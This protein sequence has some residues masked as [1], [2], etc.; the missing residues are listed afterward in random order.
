[1]P[2]KSKPLRKINAEGKNVFIE[3]HSVPSVPTL[4]PL[5]PNLVRLKDTLLK[6]AEG[7]FNKNQVKFLSG[8]GSLMESFYTLAGTEDDKEAQAKLEA[9]EMPAEFFLH[10]TP[11]MR[12]LA[13]VGLVKFLGEE[14]EE[15]FGYKS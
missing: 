15:L 2:R 1:M 9:F 13:A 6:M 14:G 7:V 4:P 3:T 5:A 12:T 8:V 11:K 10:L